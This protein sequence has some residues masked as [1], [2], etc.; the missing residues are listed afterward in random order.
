M[1]TRDVELAS[2]SAQ[3][4]ECAQHRRL[5]G[6]VAEALGEKALAARN[7]FID[8]RGA[9]QER[10]SEWA[11]ERCLL[12]PVAGPPR[13]IERPREGL[14]TSSPAARDRVNLGQQLPRLREPEVVS[15]L[16]ELRDDRRADLEDLVRGALGSVNRRTN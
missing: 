10:K 12:A 2:G 6:P 3:A 7:R 11:D 8:M 5:N 16:F 4:S 13:V 14:G 15:E 1:L 9:V